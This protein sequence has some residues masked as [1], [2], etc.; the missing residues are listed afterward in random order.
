[1]LAKFEIN[2]GEISV[3]SILLIGLKNWSM[4]SLATRRA[5]LCVA[6]E[7]LRKSFHSSVLKKLSTTALSHQSPL[8]LLLN[9][10]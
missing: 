8:S 1:L 5:W 4:Y 6:P 7:R 10:T 9:F 2:W 3:G